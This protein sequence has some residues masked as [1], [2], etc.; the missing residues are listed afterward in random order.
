[1]P[2]KGARPKS[3]RTASNTGG[4]ERNRRESLKEVMARRRKEM[5]E[6]Q[7]KEVAMRDDY[8]NS[9]SVINSF[10]KPTAYIYDSSVNEHYCLWDENYPE[11]PDRVKCIYNRGQELN[12]WERCVEIPNTEND[13]MPYIQ[14]MHNETKSIEKLKEISESTPEEQE[15]YA[16]MYD[17]VYFNKSTYKAAVTAAQAVLTLTREVA[18]GNYQNGFALVRPPGHHAMMNYYCGY[19]FFNNVAIAAN[20]MTKEGLAKRILIVDFDVHHGQATMRAFYKRSD[21]LYVSIHRHENGQFWPNL[22]ESDAMY[23]GQPDGTGYNV[24]IPLNQ[25]G[26]GDTEY[27]AIVLNIILPLAYEYN[28]DLI[29]LSAGYDACIGCPEGEMLVSPHFYGHLVNLLSGLADGKVVACLEGGY[30]LP[31]LAEGACMTIKALLGDPC[32]PLQLKPQVNHSVIETI[33]DV[34]YTLCRLW[35]CFEPLPLTEFPNFTAS[36]DERIYLVNPHE[37][38]RIF[39]YNGKPE[40]APFPTKGFYP[41]RSKAE[42]EFYEAHIKF[43]QSQMAERGNLIKKPVGYVYDD[44]MTAH[45][46]NEKPNFPEQPSRIT[47]CNELLEEFQLHKFLKQIPIKEHSDNILK[48]VTDEKY[49]ARIL[50]GI[51][52]TS[53]LFINEHTYSCAKLAL[54]SI[55]SLIDSIMDNTIGSGAAIVRPPGHHASKGKAHGFCFINNVA[56]GAQYLLD[57]Y[58]LQRV[59]I[60]DF[61]IHH[62]DGTQNLTYETEKILYVSIHHFDETFFPYLKTGDSYYTGKGPGEGFNVNI[63]FKYKNMGD[64]EYLFVFLNLV[65]PIVYSYNPEFILISAGFDAAVNDPIGSYCVMPEL[66]AHM[67]QMIKS[68]AAGR[69]LLVLE[70]GYNVNSTAYSMVNCIKALLGDPLPRIKDL[71]NIN[72]FA[73]QTFREVQALQRHYFRVLDIHPI[74]YDLEIRADKKFTIEKTLANFNTIDGVLMGLK[75]KLNVVEGASDDD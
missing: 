9:R 20:A 65:L 45:V 57:T 41:K 70:G 19:C 38:L 16:T 56:A 22:V 14:A 68:L 6:E 12:L 13:V 31:S 47:K 75:A 33:N 5:V 26:L 23:T 42:M 61:D 2:N 15:Q 50:N 18:K 29:M 62:G 35:K 27:M 66:F 17:S 11:C 28:P 4:T 46:N 30:F 36:L 25:T 64:S 44:R 7:L 74:V 48:S 73:V 51:G 21:V 59:L 72:K 52:L 39:R 8:E 32:L 3:A 55:L 58:H 40:K 69:V 37:H 60:F 1:M 49:L 53:D 24:N 63:P 10:R 71:K 34:K 67:V 54:N 43:F